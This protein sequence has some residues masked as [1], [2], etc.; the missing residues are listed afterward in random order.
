M[1]SVRFSRI[2]AN[3]YLVD[4][5]A[6]LEF[7]RSFRVHH[8]HEPQSKPPK[9]DCVHY[10]AWRWQWG[11]VWPARRRLLSCL[12]YVFERHMWEGSSP[13]P[14]ECKGRTQNVTAWSDPG[15]VRCCPGRPPGLEM[16]SLPS[17]GKFFRSLPVLSIGLCL[18]V[19]CGPYGRLWLC[20]GLNPTESCVFVAR[21][22][23]RCVT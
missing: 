9:K 5:L 12:G 4:G 16:A 22:D 14:L 19:I 1:A 15:R 18:S 10:N 11:G 2:L 8:R 7:A 13:L 17:I 20:V 21:N 23:M 6:S 3:Y